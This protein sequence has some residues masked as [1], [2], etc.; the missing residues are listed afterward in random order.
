V[1][2]PLDIF[3]KYFGL[4]LQDVYNLLLKK[5][6]TLGSAQL[7]WG[8]HQLI[9]LYHPKQVRLLEGFWRGRDTDLVVSLVPNFDRALVESVRKAL[10]GVPFATIWSLDFTDDFFRR[11]LRQW[12]ATGRIEHDL[13]HVR[14]LDPAASI[15]LVFAPD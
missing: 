2:D 8:M 4:R 10:P 7:L 15:A 1:L 14:P 9:R 13:S 5:G 3:R 6:W 12:L 11:G